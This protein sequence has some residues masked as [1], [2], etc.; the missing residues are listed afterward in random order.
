MHEAT[1]EKGTFKSSSYNLQFRDSQPGLFMYTVFTNIMDLRHK[2]ETRVSAKQH[3]DR[4]AKTKVNT[5]CQ[6]E[7]LMVLVIECVFMLNS[8]TFPTMSSLCTCSLHWLLRIL[9]S[10]AKSSQSR[11]TTVYQ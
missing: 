5:E 2:E 10:S 1:Y 4:G 9:I 7:I 8:L 6:Y 3:P 11:L